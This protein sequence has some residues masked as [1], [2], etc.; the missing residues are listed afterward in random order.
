MLPAEIASTAANPRMIFARNLRVGNSVRLDG[1]AIRP[2]IPTP[3][4]VVSRDL[5]APRPRT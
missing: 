3:N 5:E 2:D 4:F 1:D